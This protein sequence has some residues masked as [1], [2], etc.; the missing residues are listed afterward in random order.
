MK[1]IV[2]LIT[3]FCILIGIF[4]APIS[5]A[6][7]RSADSPC[8]YCGVGT[9]STS[10]VRT[11]KGNVIIPCEHGLKGYD[12]VTEYE[13]KT[14]TLCSNCDYSRES[15]YTQHVLITCGGYNET[16]DWI[17]VLPNLNLMN[18]R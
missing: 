10:I 8:L 11:D 3:C 2:P 1:R 17:V 5:A 7:A 12:F 15:T 13:V 6:E 18:L 14:H 16:L 4:V 9:L